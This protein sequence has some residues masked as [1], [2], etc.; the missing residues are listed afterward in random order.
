MRIDGLPLGQNFTTGTIA[1]IL[2]RLNIGD[3]FR[4]QILDI[5]VNEVLLKMVDGATLTAASLAPVNAEKGDFVDFVVKSKN[6]GRMMLETVK[7]DMA[8]PRGD[9]D[10]I[11]KL[12][13]SLDLKPTSQNTEIAREIKAFNLPATREIFNLVKDL[14]TGFKELAPSK[15]AFMVSNDIKPEIRNIQ[16]LNQLAD[17]RFKL[18]SSL[19]EL[20]VLLSGIEDADVL[21][22]LQKELKLLSEAKAAPGTTEKT[23]PQNQSPRP[24]EETGFKPDPNIA[25]T[26]SAPGA[27]EL[28]KP[29]LIKSIVN[30]NVDTALKTVPSGAGELKDSSRISPGVPA[31][32][33]EGDLP[34][35]MPKEPLPLPKDAASEK[36]GIKQEMENIPDRGKL[37]AGDAR[38]AVK[39]AF[40]EVFTRIG[41]KEADK[42]EVNKSYRE[43]YEKLETVKA[44]LASTVLPNREDLLTRIDNLQNN[45]KF[46]NEINTNSSY[47]QI[48]LNIQHNKT[49][50]ELYVLKRDSKRKKIDP[51]NMTFLLSLNTQNLGQVDSIVTVSKK[52]VSVNLRVEDKSIFDFIKNSYKLLHDSLAKSGYKLVDLKYRM[53][54]E[55]ANILNME[56]MLQK[57]FTSKVS[58]DYRI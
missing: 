32:A 22:T 31:S 8:N 58:V 50:G 11:Q 3:V 46:I 14:V 17:N 53:V 12:L 37:P 21:N 26:R 9:T 30:E 40:D 57:E 6:D 47:I 29:V 13:L 10:D 25:G 49:T 28:S 16:S 44:V 38:E 55:A 33:A 34:V 1:D 41:G 19:N 2:S 48:P 23:L 39:K 7:K 42:L 52:N 24:A 5:A 4:A 36:L 15:A 56:K 27:E 51:G 20:S 18:G 54:D 35:A 45:I 43:L